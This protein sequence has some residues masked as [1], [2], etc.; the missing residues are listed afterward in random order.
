MR[1]VVGADTCPNSVVTVTLTGYDPS[2][3]GVPARVSV[4][5]ER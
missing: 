2:L 5:P 1:D 3:V 4:R